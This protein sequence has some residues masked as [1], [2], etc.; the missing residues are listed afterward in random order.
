MQD[1]RKRIILVTE[2]FESTMS[3]PEAWAFN[4]SR[5][6]NKLGHDVRIFTMLRDPINNRVRH[7]PFETNFKGIPV[8]FYSPLK[9]DFSDVNN[10]AYASLYDSFAHILKDKF[11]NKIDLMVVDHTT[12]TTHA[13][14]WARSNNV[15]YIVSHPD[16]SSVCRYNKWSLPT[17]TKEGFCPC[18][19][20][21]ACLKNQPLGVDKIGFFNTALINIFPSSYLRERTFNVGMPLSVA[22]KVQPSGILKPKDTVKPKRDVVNIGFIGE[23]TLVKGA[24]TLMAAWERM[25]KNKTASEKAKLILYSPEP[26]MKDSAESFL[27]YKMLALQGVSC[28]GSYTQD[29]KA[30]DNV[31][32]S[33]DILVVPS[34]WPENSP[35]VISEAL[36]RGTAVVASDVPGVKD[37]IV[38]DFNGNLFKTNSAEELFNTLNHLCYHKYMLR[39]E[40]QK[41]AQS[42]NPSKGRVTYIEDQAKYFLS[43][44]GA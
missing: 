39:S 14:N 28:R 32:K 37:Q 43:F 31:H 29:V 11:E 42:A 18:K 10:E 3:G 23:L 21:Y 9:N 12:A 33:L 30:I 2:N 40:Q 19:S 8:T 6:L 27:F 17:N 38:K 5:E 25:I 24:V 13:M 1:A 36:S 15:P 22:N 7:F 26:I 4:L 35:R 16:Y 20:G 44:I 41:A 34:L